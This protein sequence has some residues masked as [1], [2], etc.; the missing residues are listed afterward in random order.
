MVGAE[1][2][3]LSTDFGLRGFEMELRVWWIPQVPDNHSF[4]VMVVSVRQAH[5]VVDV[6]ARYDLYQYEHKVKPDYTNA[7]GLQVKYPD[8]EWID[9]YDDETG[10]DF[11]EFRARVFP[12]NVI[13]DEI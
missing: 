4:I 8:G 7:G 6:L 9:W 5:L 2:S 13:G 12:V 11:D 10:E 3:A 1:R